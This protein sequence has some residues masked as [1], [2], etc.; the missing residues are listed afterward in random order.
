MCGWL[1]PTLI[2]FIIN[3]LLVVNFMGHLVHLPA[4]HTCIYVL[5]K[6]KI[7]W[8]F[9]IE[10]NFAVP[11]IDLTWMLIH[12]M[13]LGFVTFL[14]PIMPTGSQ[15]TC[16]YIS[17]TWGLRSRELILVFIFLPWPENLWIKGTLN[18]VNTKG[19]CIYC[20]SDQRIRRFYTL[21]AKKKMV[22]KLMTCSFS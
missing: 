16:D 21:V 14:T 13:Q 7:F 6:S 8:T 15:L 1:H 11:G 4:D 9:A 17:Y 12:I 19:L 20:V 10:N 5:P 2:Y 3:L 18:Y 22:V